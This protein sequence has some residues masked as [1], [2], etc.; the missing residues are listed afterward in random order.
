MTV[1]S[2]ALVG[3]AGLLSAMSASMPAIADELALVDPAAPA[4]GAI[5]D[6]SVI[7]SQFSQALAAAPYSGWYGGAGGGVSLGCGEAVAATKPW[8]F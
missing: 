5:Y 3:F 2:F 4:A 1:K 7:Q 6:E 8:S